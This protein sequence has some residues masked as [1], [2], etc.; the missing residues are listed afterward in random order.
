MKTFIA[1]TLLFIL[2]IFAAPV[3]QAQ[4]TD[5]LRQLVVSESSVTLSSVVAAYAVGDR[6][7][8]TTA[9]KIL[10]ATSIPTWHNPDCAGEIRNV[11]LDMDSISTGYFR[12]YAL[13]DTVGVQAALANDNAA[14]QFT[15]AVRTNLIG[16]GTLTLKTEGTTGVT[17]ADT[18]YTHT[19]RLLAGK[20]KIYWI[21][22]AASA[23]TAKQAGTM[24]LT[25]TT[26]V[27]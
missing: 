11:R 27:R 12:F 25:A 5:G 8:S 7:A 6:V 4:S 23:Y 21:V 18:A 13:K 15:T 17:F 10:L 19:F 26:E 22:V 14:F 16:Q 20:S 2:S 1:A 24:K 3:V 9:N